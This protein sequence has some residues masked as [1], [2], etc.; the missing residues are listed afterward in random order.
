[1]RSPF[2]MQPTDDGGR[3]RRSLGRLCAAFRSPKR[4]GRFE[5]AFG[6]TKLSP[7]PG[8][9]ALRKLG[10]DGDPVRRKYANPPGWF[11]RFWFTRDTHALNGKPIPFGINGEE[12]SLA[13]QNVNGVSWRAG[14]FGFPRGDSMAKKQ[15]NR[16][17]PLKTFTSG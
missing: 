2:P 14:M 7:S 3:M 6:R 12:C 9:L 5:G 17:R 10:P 15:G 13:A 1:L 8:G 16:Q 4:V 11:A